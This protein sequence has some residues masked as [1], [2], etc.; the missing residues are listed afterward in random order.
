MKKYI[1]GI[2]F[3]FCLR[4]VSRLGD[5]GGM[6]NV[7]RGML[8]LLCHNNFADSQGIVIFEHSKKIKRELL[9][10]KERLPLKM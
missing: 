8:S 7:N 1:L 5:S 10:Q 3:I 6:I 9:I 2:V 4:S